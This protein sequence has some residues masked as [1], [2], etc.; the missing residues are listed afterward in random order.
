MLKAVH[1]FSVMWNQGTFTKNLNHIVRDTWYHIWYILI[2][3]IALLIHP[4]WYCILVRTNNIREYITFLTLNDPSPP[5]WQLLGKQ[6]E[7]LKV[8]IQ[9]QQKVNKLYLN[10]SLVT[11]C[12]VPR[13]NFAQCYKIRHPKRSFHHFDCGTCINFG[14]HFLSRGLCFLQQRFSNGCGRGYLE[15]G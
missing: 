15:K 2:C 7:W 14:I 12:C 8:W 11:G 5:H 1:F 3:V 4:F 13:R 10:D 6:S 9:P